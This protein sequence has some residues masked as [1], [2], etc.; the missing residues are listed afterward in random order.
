MAVCGH[1]DHLRILQAVPNDIKHEFVLVELGLDLP[2][3]APIGM[4]R[5]ECGSV[6]ACFYALNAASYTRTLS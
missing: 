3:S 1:I 5:E 4:W 6:S 2:V